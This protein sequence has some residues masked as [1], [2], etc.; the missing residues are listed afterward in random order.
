MRLMV[1]LHCGARTCSGLNFCEQAAIET[2]VLEKGR[3]EARG[4]LR[5]KKQF[6]LNHLWMHPQSLGHMKLIAQGHIVKWS[7]RSLEKN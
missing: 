7:Q 3:V 1:V 2:M 4:E 6:G 5:G